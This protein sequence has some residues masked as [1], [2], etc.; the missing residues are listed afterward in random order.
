[1]SPSC[2]LFRL[3][4]LSSVLFYRHCCDQVSRQISSLD[5]FNR[6]MLERSSMTLKKAFYSCELLHFISKQPS[7][8]RQLN[9]YTRQLSPNNANK[10]VLGCGTAGPTPLFVLQGRARFFP[11]ASSH[12]LLRVGPLLPADSTWPSVSPI[13]SVQQGR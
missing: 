6:L 11:L 9:P 3:Q 12:V 2:T 1:M 7:L 8:I 10:P 13:H 4:Y 5:E